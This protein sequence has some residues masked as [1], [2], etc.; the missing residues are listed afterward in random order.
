MEKSLKKQIKKYITLALV[1]AIVVLLAVLP[2]LAGETVLD[3]GPVASVLM[4]QVRLRDISTVVKGGGTLEEEEMVEITIPS[5]V[6]LKSFLVDNDDYVREGDPV[7]EVDRVSVM[8]AITKVQETMEYLNEKIE[9]TRDTKLSDTIAATVDGRVK[10]V[11]GAAGDSVRDVMLEHGALAVLS[12]DGMMAVEIRTEESVQIGDRLWIIFEDGTKAEANVESSLDGTVVVTLEDQGYKADTQVAVWNENVELGKGELYIHNRWNVTGFSGTISKV[13]LKEETTVSAGK[14]I[15]TLKDVAFTAEFQT[16]LGQRQ[17]YEELMLKLFRM[18]QNTTVNAPGEGR[19]SGVEADSAFLLGNLDHDGLV[20]DLLTNGPA[21]QDGYTNLVVQVASVK[22]NGWEL[23]INSTPVD[24]TDYAEFVTTYAGSTF[25]DVSEYTHNEA[26]QIYG[27]EN[28]QWVILTA[29]D[30]AENDELLVAFDGD[31]VVW[32]VRL[33]DAVAEPEVIPPA[34]GTTPMPG[35]PG[36][37]GMGGIF[38]GMGGYQEEET[39]ELYSLEESIIMAVTAQEEMTLNITVDESDISR[40]HVGQEA[41]IRLDALRNDRFTGMITELGSTGENNGGSSKFTVTIVMERSE[42]MLAGMNATATI[43]LDTQKD[44]L[45]IPVAAIYEENGKTFVYTSY[46]GEKDILGNPVE[47]EL[48]VSDGEYVEVL[49]G[50]KEGQDF[51]Y[52]YYDTLDISTDTIPENY[53]GISMM[54][55]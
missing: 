21:V 24:V 18:Y 54:G 20:L 7:A 28:D 10:Y 49:S 32:V 41:K 29:A 48:G 31:V 46:D 35:N 39:F 14:T 15:F 26:V 19:I 1:A 52:A 6:K 43:V 44:L 25:D 47:V 55:K 42:D 8:T 34:G 27:L 12:L 5:G 38:G 11:Y 37:G 22:E 9:E 50:L 51:W 45:S 3:D 23:K 36:F 17:E 33:V 13:H 53:F 2:M 40:L 30:I 16:L 4:D